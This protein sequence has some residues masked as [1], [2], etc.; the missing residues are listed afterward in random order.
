MTTWVDEVLAG[1]ERYDIKDDGGTT[2]H[3]NVQIILK[4]AVS[5]AGT[6]V[7]ASKMNAIETSISN[8]LRIAS[9]GIVFDS[10]TA[11]ATGDDKLCTPVP[12]LC[13]GMNITSVK[14]WIRTKSSSGVVTVTLERGRQATPT[15]DFSFVDVLSTGVTIDAGEYCSGTATTPYVIDTS[16]DDLAAGDILRWNVDGIGTGT[17]GLYVEAEA[18]CP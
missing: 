12:D 1:P 3:G 18:R 15:S 2:L 16:K 6:N 4:T 14:I 17:K 8:L 9:A 13:A 7:D 11:L 10:A 5:V